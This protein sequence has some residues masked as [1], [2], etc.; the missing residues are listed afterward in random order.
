ML[1]VGKRLSGFVLL[2]TRG[3][4]SRPSSRHRNRSLQFGFVAER[5][6]CICLLNA[7]QTCG[8]VEGACGCQRNFSYFFRGDGT[9]PVAVSTPHAYVS[10]VLR[11]RSFCNAQKSGEQMRVLT[12]SCQSQEQSNYRHMV[13]ISHNKYLPGRMWQPQDISSG[14]VA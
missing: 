10:V 3:K 4:P 5:R 11:E 9:V 8:N 1:L 13:V 6:H 12:G 7:T 14:A 2:Q